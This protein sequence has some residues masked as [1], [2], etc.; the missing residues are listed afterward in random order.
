MDLKLT[1]NKHG[2]GLVVSFGTADQ[3]GINYLPAAANM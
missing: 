3:F 1:S 2:F